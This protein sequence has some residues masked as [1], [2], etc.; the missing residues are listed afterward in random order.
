MATLHE[1]NES[2]A[3]LIDQLEQMDESTP[4]QEA[5]FIKECLE[6]AQ[7]Q[8]EEKILSIARWRKQL[9]NE[10]KEVLGGELKRLQRRRE[11]YRK[12]IES[13]GMY[14]HWALSET[15]G[16]I[17]SPLGSVW[18]QSNSKP[19]VTITDVT[20]IPDEY[21]SEKYTAQSDDIITVSMGEYKIKVVDDTVRLMVVDKDRIAEYWAETGEQVPGTETSRG[22]HV[23]FR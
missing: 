21:W 7:M 17:K 5:R 16:K 8:R 15:G 10:E 4:E 12:R 18:I 2:I 22:T 20:Q 23:Q 9:Q 3:F 19:T 13:L 1:I 11:S 6:A 14:L